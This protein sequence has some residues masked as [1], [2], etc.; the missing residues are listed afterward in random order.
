[1]FLHKNHHAGVSSLQIGPRLSYEQKAA[2]ENDKR[3]LPNTGRHKA[4]REI[5]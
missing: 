1:M 4:E 3:N 5:S 2:K